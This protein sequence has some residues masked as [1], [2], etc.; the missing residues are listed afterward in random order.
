M[1]PTDQPSGSSQMLRIDLPSTLITFLL[2][3]RSLG[4]PFT[5]RRSTRKPPSLCLTDRGAGAPPQ[6]ASAQPCHRPRHAADLLRNPLKR[7]EFSLN[8]HFA[9]GCCLSR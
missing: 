5:G 3:F 8:R 2:S 1:I 4:V 6:L 9:L 7:N